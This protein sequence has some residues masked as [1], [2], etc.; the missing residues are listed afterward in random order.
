MLRDNLSSVDVIISLA[1]YLP[2]KVSDCLE[3]LPHP[4][5][6]TKAHY[7]ETIPG[8]L[9]RQEPHVGCMPHQGPWAWLVHSTALTNITF[10]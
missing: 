4:S 5:D 6:L 3:A 10:A 1:D 2:H 7:C 8:Q 9:T